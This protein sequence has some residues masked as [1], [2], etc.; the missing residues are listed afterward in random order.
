MVMIPNSPIEQISAVYPHKIIICSN[1]F[2]NRGARRLEEM[3]LT[4][5]IMFKQPGI[6][7]NNSVLVFF[8]FVST[9][10]YYVLNANQLNY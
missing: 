10:V 7:S 6:F 5:K 1:H 2:P 4:E 3:C 9:L 8:A